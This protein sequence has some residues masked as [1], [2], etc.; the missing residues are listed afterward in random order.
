MAARQQNFLELLSQAILQ[1]C[2]AV[3]NV[4][5]H[6]HSL[7]SVAFHS[8]QQNIK[9]SRSY[10]DSSLVDTKYATDNSKDG[11]TTG[12]PIDVPASLNGLMIEGSVCREDQLAVLSHAR[13]VLSDDGYLFLFGE[14][15]DD[16]SKIEHS[17]LANL[18]SLHRQ[19]E[20]LGFG[21]IDEQD[22]SEDA[23]RCIQWLSDHVKQNS[24]AIAQA[25]NLNSAELDIQITELD[26]INN[27]FQS[28]RRCFRFFIFQK[29]ANQ[30]G[31]YAQAEYGDI[32]SFEAAEIKGL[33]EASFGVDFDPELW[34]WKY[35]LGE[36]VCVVARAEPGGEIVAHYGGAPRKIH[37]FG[38]PSWALQS[39]DVMVLP[40]M[41][42]QYGRNSLFFKTAATFLEREEG[43]TANHLLGFG[44]PN[45]KAMNIALRLGL[46]E[47]TD[48][49]IE[50][51]VPYSGELNTDYKL[52]QVNIDNSTH[53]QIIDRL[54]QSM[55]VDFK[56]AII[57]VRNA[58]YIRY[59]YFQHPFA[60][61]GQ[62]R[63][64]LISAKDGKE[65]KA[66]FAIKSHDEG[67]LLMDLI[68]DISDFQNTLAIANALVRENGDQGNLKFWITRGW[69]QRLQLPESAVKELGIEIPC[70]SWNP[71]PSAET[72]YGA[73]WLTAGDMDFI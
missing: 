13:E 29:Q 60:E 15:L 30:A 17:R 25:L 67:Q 6:G 46:Y 3:S 59:R 12:Y 63:A 5:F 34:H 11:Q 32:R 7:A 50:V 19:S 35:Q 24:G 40:E 43:N 14:Y 38:D 56:N 33:F 23:Q 16:D 51:G 8:D 4:H 65:V 69:Q 52:E 31:E 72:L 73:W 48:D 37:Y 66:F 53:R 45:Q 20:R 39:C 64:F 55:S 28:G 2:P 1:H 54:W 58:D 10:P 44:F 57:G 61:R 9:T 62:Y 70:N 26:L 68:C 47:K 49:F 71:G 36:G 27:E 22:F 41:R 18:S 21:I 42:R